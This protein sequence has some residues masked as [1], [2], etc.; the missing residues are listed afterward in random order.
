MVS[1]GSCEKMTDRRRQ[2]LRI[3]LALREFSEQGVNPFGH[4]A[5]PVKEDDVLIVYPTAPATHAIANF[6]QQLFLSDLNTQLGRDRFQL[7]ERRVLLSSTTAPT[8][9]L[10]LSHNS[11][12]TKARKL[13]KRSLSRLSLLRAGRRVGNI[14]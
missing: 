7:S 3:N 6:T 10:L 9:R 2:R 8:T 1:C 12:V 14:P 5:V 4:R 13:V 11:I